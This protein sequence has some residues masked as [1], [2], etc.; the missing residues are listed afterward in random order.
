MTY[1]LS[2]IMTTANNLRKAYGLSKSEALT[3]S[4]AMEKLAALKSRKAA[5]ENIDRWNNANWQTVN[6][7]T[8]E[9][10]A[11]ESK[12]YPTVTKTYTVWHGYNPQAFFEAKLVKIAAEKGTDSTEY[13]R[14]MDTIARNL[15]THTNTVLDRAAYA[16]AA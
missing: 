10:N 3:K 6:A 16:L 14:T 8:A 13:T 15:T 11:L 2:T 9:I 4:W 7:L 5:L 1:N 12:I